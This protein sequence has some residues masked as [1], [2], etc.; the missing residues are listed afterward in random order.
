MGN[1]LLG[2]EVGE[3]TVVGRKKALRVFEPLAL[4]GENPPEWLPRYEAGLAACRVKDWQAALASFQS[5]ADDPVSRAYTVRCL[6]LLQGR[7][8][9]WNGVWNLTEK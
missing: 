9:D 5:I 7:L 2:R 8:P 3:I 4:P 6:D 1:N